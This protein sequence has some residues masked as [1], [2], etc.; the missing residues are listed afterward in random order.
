VGGI[1]TGDD[2]CVVDVDD[3]DDDDDGVSEDDRGGKSD[4]YNTDTDIALSD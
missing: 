3:D 4:H 1:Y 2:G